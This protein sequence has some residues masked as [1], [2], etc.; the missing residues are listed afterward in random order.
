VFPVTSTGED[1]VAVPSPFVVV[2]RDQMN[3]PAVRAGVDVLHPLVG[4]TVSD[5]PTAYSVTTLTTPSAT[6]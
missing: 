6:A 3:V 5:D 2:V 4:A 1:V